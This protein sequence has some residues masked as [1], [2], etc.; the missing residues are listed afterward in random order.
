MHYSI[1]TNCMINEPL[2]KA[3]EIISGHTEYAEIMC[4]GPH[5]I[6]NTEILE[7][8]NLKYSIHAPA[9]GVNIASCLEPVRKAASDTICSTIHTASEIGADVIIHPGFFAWESEYQAAEKSLCS[10]LSE[11]KSASEETDTKYYIE[12]MGNWGYFFM[13]TPKDIKLLNGAEICLDVGHANE[14]GT[15]DEFLKLPFSHVHLHDNLGK[16]DNHMQIGLGNIDFAKVMKKVEENNIAHP[17]IETSDFNAALKSIE[18]L[19]RLK[20]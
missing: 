15:L 16:K 7:S 6:Q 11:I 5:Y 3:L 20:T 14:C 18:Y 13:K 2:S 10:S 8:F 17:V 9:R 12:N 19:E 4:D 1:S